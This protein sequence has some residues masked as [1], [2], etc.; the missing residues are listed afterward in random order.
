MLNSEVD[1]LLDVS[2]FDLLVDDDTDCAL[3]DIVDDASLSVVD[4]GGISTPSQ[5]PCISIFTL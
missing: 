4:L 2:V 5:N 1:S 3:C